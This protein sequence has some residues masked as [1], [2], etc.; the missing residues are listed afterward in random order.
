MSES[1]RIVLTLILLALTIFILAPTT[2][3]LWY[4][5]GNRLVPAAGTQTMQLPD[6]AGVDLSTREA[7]S[8]CYDPTVDGGRIKFK[9]GDGTWR[10]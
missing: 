5:W 8:I 9:D 10:F 2:T 4:V 7:G 6:C 3:E 1:R